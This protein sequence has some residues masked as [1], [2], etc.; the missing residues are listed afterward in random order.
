LKADSSP[1]TVRLSESRNS[2]SARASLAQSID[3]KL[4]DLGAALT[5]GLELLKQ[6]Q[7]AVSTKFDIPQSERIGVGFWGAGRGCG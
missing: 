7:T 2:V 5:K 4:D 3:K 1:A 6:V